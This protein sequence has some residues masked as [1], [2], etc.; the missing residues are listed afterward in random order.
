VRAFWAA[1]FIAARLLNNLPSSNHVAFRD[2]W[3]IS[4]VRAHAGCVRTQVSR[5]LM[6]KYPAA[7]RSGPTSCEKLLA[8]LACVACGRLGLRERSLEIASRPPAHTRPPR[9]GCKS[10]V[11]PKGSAKPAP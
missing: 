9:A 3:C 7:K 5:I 4:S 11:G 1:T 8:C 2:S 6:H 10:Q